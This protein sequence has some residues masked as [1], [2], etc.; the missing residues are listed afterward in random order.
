LTQGG[1]L[2]ILRFLAVAGTM[3]M[4]I[5]SVTKA[6]AQFSPS[7]FLSTPSSLKNQV[8]DKIT[9][10]WIYLDGRPL[11]NITASKTNF[12]ARFQNIQQNLQDITHNY[13]QTSAA[14]IK[15]QNRIVKGL[16]NI[17]VNDQYLMTVTYE[18]A[19]QINPLTLANQISDEL[20][21]HLKQAKQERQSHFS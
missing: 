3:V 2:V 10:G 4:T 8:D 14:E 11:F 9:S 19:R 20:Q 12:P 18:D 21:Q 17:Y 13:L 6:T 5:S 15:V 1:V 16:P 7:P